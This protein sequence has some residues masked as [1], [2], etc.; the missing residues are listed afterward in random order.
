MKHDHVAVTVLIV[1]GLLLGGG[2][3]LAQQSP[4]GAGPGPGYRHGPRARIGH[5]GGGE[6][7]WMRA[8]KALDLSME[9]VQ[10]IARVRADMIVKT[11][12]LQAQL[13][14]KELELR[15]LWLAA[16]PDRRAIVAKHNEIDALRRQVRDARID[17]RLGVYQVLT[18]AQRDQVRQ[19]IEDRRAGP[20]KGWGRKGRAGT[21]GPPGADMPM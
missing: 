8:I 14:V 20:H 6:M 5:G 16:T 13:Q 1:L 3:A 11:A 10:G 4:E 18:T 9:Q 15:N 21:A 19:A 12:P 7:G 17:F 2:E